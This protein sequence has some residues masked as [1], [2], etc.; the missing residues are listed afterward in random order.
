[1]LLLTSGPKHLGWSKVAHLLL[2]SRSVTGQ[3]LSPAIASFSSITKI[4]L[5]Y[6]PAFS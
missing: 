1:M 4:C 5:F 3:D 2:L 6:F